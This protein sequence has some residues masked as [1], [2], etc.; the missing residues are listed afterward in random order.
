MTRQAQVGA[1][2][3]LA[4]LALFGIFY[5]I[6]NLNVRSTGYRVGVHFQS[7]AGLTPA[8]LVYFS[9]VNVG[10]VD[11][12]NL[13]PD[14]TVEVVLAVNRDLDIPSE[15]KFIIQAPLTGSPNVL[16]V[17]P[18]PRPGLALLPKQ[19]LPIEQQPQGANTATIADLLQQGQGE[20]KRFD[21]IMAEMQARTPKLLDSLQTTLNNAN[22]LT[23]TAKESMQQLAAQMSS[24]GNNLQASLTTASANI[25]DLTSTLNA[26]AKS[27]SVKVTTLLD[28][29][30]STSIA[31]NNSMN[32][33]EGFAT[34]PKLKQNLL[35][36]TQSIADATATMALLAKDLRTVTGD[37]QTQ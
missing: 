13:L 32:A 22:E 23:L 5:F 8:A 2:T 26:S 1:F 35:Q 6:T 27:D 33:L 19:V 21:V 3:L 18:A 31:L 4:L 10:S 14:N 36:T 37:P 12:I 16:I 15:S 28:K 7:A 29:L 24:I 20:I 11:S 17:P 25:D 30:N 9:G 34:D